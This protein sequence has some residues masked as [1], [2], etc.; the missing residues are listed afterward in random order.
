M[1]ISFQNLTHDN[2]WKTLFL[3][4]ADPKLIYLGT[5]QKVM[6]QLNHVWHIRGGVPGSK[7]GRLFASAEKYSFPQT[8]QTNLLLLSFFRFTTLFLISWITILH[9]SSYSSIG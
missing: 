9:F 3:R 6:S 2:I 8:F 4:N 1:P 5:H 7:L